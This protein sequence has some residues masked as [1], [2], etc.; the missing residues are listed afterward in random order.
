MGAEFFSQGR[1]ASKWQGWDLNPGSFDLESMLLAT[2]FCCDL[3]LRP[4]FRQA[5]NEKHH[6][7]G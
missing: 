1:S 4:I 2:L 6:S 3:I 5:Y 7:K